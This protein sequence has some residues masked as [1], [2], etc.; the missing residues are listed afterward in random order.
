MP[1][2]GGVGPDQTNNVENSREPQ[3]ELK[4]VTLFHI[5]KLDPQRLQV[6]TDVLSLSQSC[7]KQNNDTT[8][9]GMFTLRI[10]LFAHACSVSYRIIVFKVEELMPLEWKNNSK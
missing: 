1:V 10:K 4:V 2:V 9:F 7:K 6:H 5:L 3:R 8:S